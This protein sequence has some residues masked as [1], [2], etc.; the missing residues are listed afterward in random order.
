M[1][2]SCALLDIP[3]TSQ[4]GYCTPEMGMS[5]I[6]H[7]D[8]VRRLNRRAGQRQRLNSP[9]APRSLG[10][11]LESNDPGDGRSSRQL[12][13]RR[14]AGPVTYVAGRRSAPQIVVIAQLEVLERARAGS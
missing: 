12:L 9:V 11:S 1:A 10:P 2:S 13:A 6:T 8:T 4:V 3:F 5:T 7:M 14:I